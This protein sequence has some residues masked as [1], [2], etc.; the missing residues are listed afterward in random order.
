MTICNVP[1]KLFINNEWVAPTNNATDEVINPATEEVLALA[2]V[3]STEN[4]EDAISSARQAFD[5]GPW[6][7]MSMAERVAVMQKMHDFFQDNK[8]RVVELIVK[9]AGSTQMLADAMQFDIPMKH[10]RR[11]MV[12]AM[13][14]EPSLTPIEIVPMPQG[15]IL[16]TSETSYM[17]MGVV[18]AI[19]PYNF[20]F[21]LNLVKVFHALLMGNS[22][23]LKPSPFTPFQALIFGEAA[24]ACGLPAGVLNIITG[25]V[26]TGESL[27][28]DERIDMV[29]FTGSD[30]VGSLIM[31]QGAPGLKKMHLELGGKSALI[32]RA[33]ADMPMAL[34]TAL[35]NFTTHCGQ[36]CA[37]TTRILVDNRIRKE[38]VTQLAAMT[39]GLKVGDTS[40]PTVAM[41]PLIREQARQRVEKYVD[42]G[43][44]E[45][46]R[47]V[48]GG[49]RPAG[50][51]KGFFYEATLFDDVDNRSRLAQEEIFGPV[52]VVIG[53]DTDE[54]AIALANDSRFGLGGG[55]FSADAGRAYEMARQIRTGTVA[56]NG[57][58][59]TMLSA[60]PFGGIKRSGI[61]REYGVDSLLEFAEARSIS[62]H[63]G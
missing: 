28:R 48:A 10:A 2:P 36:G 24:L 4:L 6:P 50:L 11:L 41:G 15:K 22:C 46:A 58:A 51:E 37:L 25:D 60:A 47:L 55:I 8:A 13:R 5:S 57:G 52:G 14:V 26:A 17:P 30:N 19:T 54:E 27:T 62:F 59:Y 56:I 44:S 43:V 16:A 38:F 9:E 7:Q 34:Y 20:P 29:S 45:G 63:A 42:I 3:G 32:V 49:K 39:A 33:D 40:D 21:F 35:G 12:D 61:G 1:A 31:A 53:Y 18:A 23:V